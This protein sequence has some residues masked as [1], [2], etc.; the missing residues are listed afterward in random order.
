MSNVLANA[1][2]LIRKP[3]PEVFVAFCQPQWLEQFWLRHASA[4]LAPDAV[5]E[6][7]FMVEGA[8]ETVTVTGFVADQRIAFTWSDGI[9]VTLAF[10]AHGD[11]ATRVSVTAGGFRGDDAVAQAINATEG[12][13]IVL[14][15]LKSL[16]E[17]GRPGH[18]VRDKAAL[19]SAGKPQP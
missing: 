16:L 18:M 15:D 12:F 11:G 7:D 8:R 4:P 6:W 19:I 1:E 9:A 14:C 17:T 13:S 10:A 2:M 3:P 5:V